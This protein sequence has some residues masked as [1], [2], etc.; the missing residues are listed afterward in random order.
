L[1]DLWRVW[2]EVYSKLGEDTTPC[3]AIAQCSQLDGLLML[4]EGTH[5]TQ[6]A[7]LKQR[8]GYQHLQNST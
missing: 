3:L 2:E 4:C 7:C 6:L 5:Q 8:R 1:P